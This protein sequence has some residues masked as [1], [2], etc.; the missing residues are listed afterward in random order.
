MQ[1]IRLAAAI[2]ATSLLGVTAAYAQKLPD[3]YP[4][5]YSTIVE[6]SKKENKLVVYSIMAEYNWKPVVEGFKKLYPW[7]EVQTLDLVSSE[8]LGRD[9]S[10]RASNSRTGDL[11]IAGGVERWL[12]LIAKGEANDYASH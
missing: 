6:A 1:R 7:I 3:Y 12:Q 4:K 11:L 2:V 10:E 9:Y 8:V 5:S